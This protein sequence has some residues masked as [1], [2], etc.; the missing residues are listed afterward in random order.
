VEGLSSIKGRYTRIEIPLDKVENDKELFLNGDYLNIITISG[1][2][3]CEVKLDHRHSQTI[4]LREISG[5]TGVFERLFFTS[6]GGG[7]SCTL[8][9]GTGM[10]ISISSDPQKL[11]NF[12]STGIQGETLTDTVMGLS[13]VHLNLTDVSILNSSS[14]YACWVGVYINDPAIFKSYAY[15]LHPRKSIHFNAIDMYSL[16][17]ISYD[18]VHNVVINILG[19]YQ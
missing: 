14:K 10:A 8:F 7:G 18:G 5:F 4:N 15:V 19:T 6:D 3:S 12:V 9:I 2:G 13:A 1:N 11:T 17:V 16:G